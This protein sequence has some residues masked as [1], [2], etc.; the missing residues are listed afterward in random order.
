MQMIANLTMRALGGLLLLAA[1]LKAYGFTLDPIANIGVFS[2]P[3]FQVL[4]IELETLLGLWLISGSNRRLAWLVA[5]AVFMIFA[6]VSL[7]QTWI[8]QASCGCFGKLP[9]S[10]WFALGVDTLA[11]IA[12]AL[13]WPSPVILRKSRNTRNGLRGVGEPGLTWAF[14]GGAVFGLFVLGSSLMFG[15]VESAVAHLRGERV[16]IRPTVLDAGSGPIGD[17]RTIEIEVVNRTERAVR[18]IGGTSDCSCIVTQDLPITLAPGAT[19][20]VPFTLRFTGS[21]GLFTR[22]VEL[23]TDDP[24]APNVRVR[25]AGVCTPRKSNPAGS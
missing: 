16:S 24:E 18:L 2:A 13:A 22:T 1:G 5:V 4:V 17:V 12:L 10:P 7:Y 3:W 19:V 25:V 9:V 21:P 11:L 8:G 23:F 15:S 20:P 6:F 14:I